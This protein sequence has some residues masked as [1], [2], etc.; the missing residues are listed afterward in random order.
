[1]ACLSE[2][3]PVTTPA[4]VSPLPRTP[5]VT[6]VVETLSFLRDPGFL[7]RRFNQ[8]GDV[9]ETHLLGEHMV[10]VRGERAIT[11]LFAHG[12]RLKGWWPASVRRLVGP[13]AL[14]NRQGSAHRARR[15]VIGQLF[16]APALRRYTPAIV[17]LV[18]ALSKELLEA[19]GPAQLRGLMRRF[20]FGVI[21]TTVLGLEM[22][23]REK[24]FEDFE[25][26]SSGLFS[27][28]I[29]LPGSPFARALGARRRLL[30]RLRGVLAQVE[31]SADQGHG[32]AA[33]GLDL[34]AGGLDEAGLP[35]SD[36]DVAEQLLLLLFAGYET[37]ASSLVCLMLALLQHPETLDWL[38]EEL[39]SQCWPP[40]HGGGSPYDPAQAPR[41]DA[42]VKEVMRLT[43]PV[44]GF[45]R[46]TLQPVVLAGVQVPAERTVQVSL[47]ATH[48][49][50]DPREDLER[51]RPQRHT[52]ARCTA[53][54]L[55]F[56]GGERVCLGKALAE[57]EIRLLV[58]G[59][60]RRVH[61]A[62]V[63]HQDLSLMVI[64]SPTPRDGLL[65]RASK[66][67]G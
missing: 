44:G 64:P 65:V 15:R 53:L 1:M 4:Y 40:V 29:A 25:I 14:I 36:E 42:V 28:P 46:R 20:A 21:A 43:P 30:D 27:L 57:L 8:Y 22:D 67:L 17:D 18:E 56:G 63:P 5:A 23:D 24:L 12:D 59:V 55:P 47:R 39:D 13:L 3:K 61:L 48:R 52:D 7:Q 26:W 41:L 6:G 31:A 19:K 16:S 54:V 45:F 33:G 11:D 9:F 32:P 37:T 38:Q 51:F 49:M 60:L 34:I 50:G 58:V 62:L 2:T 35:L 10:L 66:A